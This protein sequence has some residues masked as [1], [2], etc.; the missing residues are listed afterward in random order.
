[1]AEDNAAGTPMFSDNTDF[2]QGQLWRQFFYMIGFVAL[3]GLGAWLVCRKLGGGSVGGG[4]TIRIGETVRLGPRK[5]LHLI[6]VGS[7]TL[8]V[9][10]TG[11]Q[12]SLLADVSDHVSVDEGKTDA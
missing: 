4:R 7:R 1:M 10:A 12:V 2:L 11:E 3:I 8:L 9:G 5:S 6:R